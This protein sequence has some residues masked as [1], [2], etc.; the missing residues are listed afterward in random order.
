MTNYCVNCKHAVVKNTILRCTR[1]ID[2]DRVT[3]NGESMYCATARSYDECCGS[4]GRHFEQRDGPALDPDA[5]SKKS[6][7]LFRLI[8]VVALVLG[9]GGCL[10]SFVQSYNENVKQAACAEKCAPAVSV[11]NQQTDL[12]GCVPA[13]KLP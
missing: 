5:E 12:C 9:V 3:S 1:W 4:R 11:Y 6:D 10:G 2:I 13:E 7:R 8:P